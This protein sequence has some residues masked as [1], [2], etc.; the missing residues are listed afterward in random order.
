MA[1]PKRSIELLPREEWE[2]TSFGR[3]L[4]WVLNVGRWI[5]ISTE[6][7]VILAFLSRFKLDRDLTNIYE[8]IKQKQAVIESMSSFEDRF[9]FLQ[10]RLATTNG[11]EKRQLAASKILAEVAPLVPID[12]SL[13]EMTVAD[14]EISFV[15]TALSEFGLAAFINNL[16]KSPRFENLSVGNVTSG[17]QEGIGIQF[18]LKGE[19]HGD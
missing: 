18:S 6:L 7:I 19:I 16:Q 11:L 12:V 9:R 3:L 10:T 1:A 13:T 15:A 2:K 17:S 4:K 8:E 5:V 14:K